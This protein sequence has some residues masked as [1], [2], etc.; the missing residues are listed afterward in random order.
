MV[1]VSVIGQP[2]AVALGSA[3]DGITPMTPIVVQ[4]DNASHVEQ[5]LKEIGPAHD[6]REWSAERMLFHTIGA[7]TRPVAPPESGV[8]IRLLSNEDALDHL[9][10]GLRHEISH[11]RLLFPTGV[12]FVDGLP[13]S[14]CY[15]CFTSESLWDVSIDTLEEYRGRGLATCV[16]RFM[17]DRMREQRLEPIWGALESNHSSLRLAERLGFKPLEVNI[18]F[19]RGPWAYLT[20]GYNF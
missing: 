17:I 12:A 7:A 9:P 10:S 19:S 8:S 14:F 13:V 6:G 1:A 2:H 4:E 3:L 11:A 20:G 16:V 18:V 5:L 15:G